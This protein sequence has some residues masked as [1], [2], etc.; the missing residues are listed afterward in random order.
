MGG[1]IFIVNEILTDARI[2]IARK[3][4][5][6]KHG[7]TIFAHILKTEGFKFTRLFHFIQFPTNDERRLFTMHYSTCNSFRNTDN[8]RVKSSKLGTLANSVDKIINPLN[9][10]F[11]FTVGYLTE[12]ISRFITKRHRVIN[13]RIDTLQQFLNVC[14][15]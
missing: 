5:K 3:R 10:D 2:L 15:N 9:G 14:H 1:F 11:A 4:R 13:G 7:F 6:V 12:F 8:L